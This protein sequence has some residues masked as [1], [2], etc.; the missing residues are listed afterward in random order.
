MR[1]HLDYVV[2]AEKSKQFPQ[3]E[4]FTCH[5]YSTPY[6]ELLCVYFCFKVSIPFRICK[7]I[8]SS[9]SN[10]RNPH[11]CIFYMTIC[12]TEKPSTL[13]MAFQTA[14]FFFCLCSLQDFLMYLASASWNFT[15][16]P[17][18]IPM[19]QFLMMILLWRC[20]TPYASHLCC[21]SSSIWKRSLLT[22]PEEPNLTMSVIWFVF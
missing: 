2:T 5:I 21:N 9:H 6:R 19:A 13:Q 22:S 18:C 14:F 4:A 15:S 11:S 20:K 17:R 7:S 8:S 10:Q 12:I 1:E 16:V 3:E